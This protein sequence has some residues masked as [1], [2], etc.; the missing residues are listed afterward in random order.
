MPK[1]RREPGSRLPQSNSRCL[2]AK[3]RIPSTKKGNQSRPPR[4]FSKVPRLQVVYTRSHSL[5]MI[6]IDQNCR[7]RGLPQQVVNCSTIVYWGQGQLF[8]DSALACPGA[9]Q[10]GRDDPEFL[11]AASCESD[12]TLATPGT[13][14]KVPEP[15][16][17]QP[18]LKFHSTQAITSLQCLL[19]VS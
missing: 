8:N 17:P 12:T 1:T 4:S 9:E 2:V 13:I 18:K 3:L 6:M 19:H 14:R 10:H 11:R 15:R 16:K 5:I 7:I